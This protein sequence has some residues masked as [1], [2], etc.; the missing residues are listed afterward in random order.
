[1]PGFRIAIAAVMTVFMALTIS[2]CSNDEATQ[3][4]AF[5]D[6]LQT[7]IVDKKGVSVPQL[8][9]D[10]TKSFGSYAAQYK[11]ITDFHSAMNEKISKPMEALA[12]KGA[13]TSINDAMSRKADI[14]TA[15]DGLSAL[16]ITMDEEQSTADKAHAALTQPE[17]LKPVFDKAYDKTV[18]NLANTYKEIFPATSQTFDILLKVVDFVDQHKDKI[19]ISGSMFEVSDPAVQTQLNTLLEQVNAKSQQ[20]QE[21]QQKMRAAIYGN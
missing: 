6:F 4:K 7:R 3:R 8:T 20:M 14:Q 2:A 1:M 16:R 13:I 12:A 17:D 19:T 9:A 18:S 10:E 21:A 5:I 15:Y 11:I